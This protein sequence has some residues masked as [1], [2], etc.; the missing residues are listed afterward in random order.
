MQRGYTLVELGVVMAVVAVLLSV[1]V[2]RLTG[3]VD[4]AKQERVVHELQNMSQLA[5]VFWENSG[6][7]PLAR[8]AVTSA[9]FDPYFTGANRLNPFPGNQPYFIRVRDDSPGP[10]FEIYTAIV[11]TCIPAEQQTVATV[12]PNSDV[13]VDC[14][15]CGAGQCR[16]RIERGVTPSPTAVKLRE[17]K[18]RLY[19]CTGGFEFN[20]G[21]GTWSDDT[22]GAYRDSDCSRW[23]TAYQDPVSGAFHCR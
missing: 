15:M 20:P 22:G 12:V 18:K 8:T 3:W 7:A 23:G 11:D 14:T 9:I 21:T 4:T 10:G 1:T 13:V 2:P 6:F 16:A 17:M 5:E 19:C